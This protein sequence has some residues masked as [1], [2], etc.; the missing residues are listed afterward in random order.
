MKIFLI[1]LP[2]CGKST[3]GKQLAEKLKLPFV[4]LDAEIEKSVGI[5]IKGIFKKYGESFFRKEESGQ[6]HRFGE[7][8]DDFVMA[9]GGGVPVF[10]DNMK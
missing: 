1:G 9:T 5:T 7:G 2:G 4:D 8:Y 6:L 3:L 10:F